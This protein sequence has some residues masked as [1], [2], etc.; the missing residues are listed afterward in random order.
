MDIQKALINI[1]REIGNLE[2]DD[3]KISSCNNLTELGI[4]SIELIQ[5]IVTCED[6]FNIIFEDAFMQVEIINDFQRLEEAIKRMKN[7]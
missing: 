6:C 4:S 7:G 2:Y 1:I 3:I 5:I